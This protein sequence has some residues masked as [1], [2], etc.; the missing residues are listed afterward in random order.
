MELWQVSS[1]SNKFRINIYGSLIAGM[2]MNG[3]D[4]RFVGIKPEI[5]LG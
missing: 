2:K 3:Y 4:A 5:E 1:S